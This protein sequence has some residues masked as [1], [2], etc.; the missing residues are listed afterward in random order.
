MMLLYVA[1]MAIWQAVYDPCLWTAAV[2]SHAKEQS[3]SVAVSKIHQG[4]KEAPK[5][6]QCMATCCNSASGNRAFTVRCTLS[7]QRTEQI[8]RSH[9]ATV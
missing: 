3:M 2:S 9:H 6:L 7:N 8:H 4:S 1:W 5:P